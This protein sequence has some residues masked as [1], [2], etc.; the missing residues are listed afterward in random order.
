M[1]LGLK[2]PLFW[3]M[4]VLFVCVLAAVSLRG[5]AAAAPQASAAPQAPAAGGAL[6]SDQVLKNIQV[7]HEHSGRKV[8]VLYQQLASGLEQDP[9]DN[10]ATLQ[11]CEFLRERAVRY[12]SRVAEFLLGSY[13]LRIFESVKDASRPVG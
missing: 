2:A 1:K 5:Q 6:I 11:R 12:P 3:P 13:D 7:A 9:T 8:Y 4:V 10:L